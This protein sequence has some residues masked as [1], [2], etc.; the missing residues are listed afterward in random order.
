[1]GF[2]S[3]IF[4]TTEFK[5]SLQRVCLWV[6]KTE[7]EQGREGGE[8]ESLCVLLNQKFSLLPS[9]GSGVGGMLCGFVLF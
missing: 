5:K 3:Q 9:Q 6:P 8:K 7:S 4:G 1:M 2:L